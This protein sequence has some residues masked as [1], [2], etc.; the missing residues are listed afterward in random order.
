MMG[1]GRGQEEDEEEGE[2]GP[3]EEGSEQVSAGEETESLNGSRVASGEEAASVGSPS[4]S[5]SEV[6]F[7]VWVA[8]YCCF[9]ISLL[10]LS[11]WLAVCVDL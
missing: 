9:I 1:S 4:Y 3:E 5:R 6:R 10:V 7:R 2:V 11:Q 8:S